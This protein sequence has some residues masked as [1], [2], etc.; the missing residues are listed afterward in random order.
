MHKYRVE[1]FHFHW[2]QSSNFGAEHLI[3]GKTYAAEVFQNAVYSAS[4]LN[5]TYQLNCSQVY[6][7]N[8]VGSFTRHV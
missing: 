8:Y 1:Q 3:D 7:I 4:I 5:S 2:G 6:N